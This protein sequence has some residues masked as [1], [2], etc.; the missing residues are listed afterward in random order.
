[1]YRYHEGFARGRA[2]DAGALDHRLILIGSY[3]DSVSQAYP[4]S[5]TRLMKG[6][7]EFLERDQYRALFG[8]APRPRRP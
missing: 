6:L 7:D 3:I 5:M 8:L 4:V 1:M 2:P